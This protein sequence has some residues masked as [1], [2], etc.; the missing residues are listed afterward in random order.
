MHADRELSILGFNRKG[1]Y[2]S[3]V[4]ATLRIANTTPASS[5]TK[6]ECKAHAV[7]QITEVINAA[8]TRYRL[9][10]GASSCVPFPAFADNSDKAAAMQV[11]AT[12]TRHLVTSIGVVMPSILHGAKA[13][14]DDDDDDDGSGGRSSQVNNKKDKKNKTAQELRDTQ[15]ANRSART[16]KL[17][18]GGGKDGGGKGGG[19]KDGDGKGGGGKG[20]DSGGGDNTP[21]DLASRVNDRGNS[22]PRSRGPKSIMTSRRARKHSTSPVSR[23]TSSPPASRTPANASFALRS[24]LWTRSRRP[25]P[26]TTSSGWRT[27]T[28]VAN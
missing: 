14:D 6:A 1:E 20:N 4:H 18:G 24:C 28:D 12:A 9:F 22:A 7:R 15:A 10:L 26:I 21:G 23:R 3:T 27:P 8:S 19:G 25:S 5:A 2:H 16:R 11:Q 13:N 17:Q